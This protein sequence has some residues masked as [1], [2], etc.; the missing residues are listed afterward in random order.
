MRRII[1]RRSGPHTAL[2]VA[3][4][5]EPQ[6]AANEALVA[7]HSVS[8]NRGEVTHAL[9][10]A[11]D[12]WAPGWDFAGTIVRAALDGSGPA[13]GSR[14]AGML[15]GGAW[16]ERIAVAGSHV[17]QLPQSVS[18][19]AAAALPV[20]G[21]TALFALEKGGAQARK[22]VL[23]T[24]AS[25]G[26]GQFAVQLAALYGAKVTALV[27]RNPL[28]LT[29]SAAHARIESVSADADGLAQL[30]RKR[31]D[32][33]IDG[34][35]GEV[36]SAAAKSLAPGGMLI[37]LGATAST[38]ARFDIREFFNIGRA[39]IYGFNIFEETAGESASRGLERLLSLVETGLLHVPLAYRGN[40]GEFDE[41]ARR[42][43]ASQLPG[44]A[45]LSWAA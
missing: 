41:V 8:L 18:F 30:Q 20:A 19:E 33:I 4:A 15:E 11:E 2:M 10:R 7:V 39:Q 21:L 23:I 22:E 29:Q 12:G 6:P 27:H 25:G 16:A 43:L 42:L 3:D 9:Q 38:E 36:F 1:V 28:S 13:A 24:G 40:V 34:V 17:A 37:T 35:G 32:L 14:V 5:P 26:L 44:K 31:F 45:V